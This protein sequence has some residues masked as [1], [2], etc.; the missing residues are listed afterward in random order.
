MYHKP[1]LA[2][3]L[4]VILISCEKD[5][6]AVPSPSPTPTPASY[7]TN[8]PINFTQAFSVFTDI[9]KIGDEAAANGNYAP[10][11]VVTFDSASSFDSDTLRIDFGPTNCLDFSGRSRRGII[12]C[13]YNGNYFDSLTT[14]QITFTNYYVN[15]C[16]LTGTI[17]ITNNGRDALGRMSYAY[18]SSGTVVKTSGTLIINSSNTFLRTTGESTP[19]LIDDVWIIS[20]TGTG[21]SDSGLNY[22]AAITA[23]FVWANSCLWFTQGV[24][25]ILPSGST[26][27]IIDFGIGSCDNQASLTYEGNI[28]SFSLF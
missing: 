5:E 16:Q 8:C 14:K 27:S 11:A 23:P 17:N 22:T 1:I 7:P 25:D 4:F 18:S 15:D 13:I 28:Y 9:V 19:T 20:G 26:T 6:D 21:T 2:I 10:C 12:V 3:F 24:V